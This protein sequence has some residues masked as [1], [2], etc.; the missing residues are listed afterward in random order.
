MA[1]QV[2]GNAGVTVEVDE[3]RNLNVN[4]QVIPGYPTAG[5]FYTVMGG[6][7]ATA[8]AASLAANTNLMTMRFSASSTRKAYVDRIRV[9]MGIATAGAA[10][11]VATILGLRRFTAATPTGGSARTPNRQGPAKGSA[12]DMTDVRDSNAA[13]TV[14][15]VVFGDWVGDTLVPNGSTNVAPFEWIME[16]IAPIEMTAGDGLALQTF[17]AGPATATWSFSYT[18]HWFER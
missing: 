2:Q 10:G 12:T 13:L 11:G 18:F 5:G 9:A 16:P 7:G 15:S 4:E 8:I 14:T 6:S 1:I 3:N 17:T